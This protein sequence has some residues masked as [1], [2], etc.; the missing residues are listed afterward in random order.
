MARSNKPNERQIDSVL[1]GA[2]APPGLEAIAG[3]SRDMR[4]FA[5]EPSSDVAAGHIASIASIATASPAP[6]SAVAHVSGF[7]R[8]RRRMVLSSL[9]SGVVAKVFAASVALATVTGGVAATGALPDAVQ[10]PIAGVYNSV[11]FDFPT[12]DG[13]DSDDCS[14]AQDPDEQ[15]PT[16]DPSDGKNRGPN[17]TNGNR[18]GPDNTEG[19]KNGPGDNNPNDPGN[20][21]GKGPGNNNGTGP[22]NNNG[23]GPGDNNGEAPGNG[24]RQDGGDEG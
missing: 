12:S 23:K 6:A 15:S 8:L 18:N 5:A 2:A 22:G 21:N 3:W 1:S 4:R 16:I 10:D 11:G 24:S 13:C 17:N 7:Q 9:L 20:N 14:D 19:N